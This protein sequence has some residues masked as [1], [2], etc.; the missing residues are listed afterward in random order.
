[1]NTVYKIM[2]AASLI[3]L[4][5]CEEQKKN[6]LRGFP[7][8]QFFSE[9]DYEPLTMHDVGSEIDPSDQ[10]WIYETRGTCG[11]VIA[12]LRQYPELEYRLFFTYVGKGP[13]P[14]LDELWVFALRPFK[15]TGIPSIEWHTYIDLPNLRYG[16]YE[17]PDEYVGRIWIELIPNSKN[18]T[19]GL[20]IRMVEQAIDFNS[21]IHK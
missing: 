11:S 4:S 18:K 14:N 8:S 19:F 13:M 21:S 10:P 7:A 17:L 16:E 20:H 12:P 1:M 2:L 15:D 6:T 5:A 3:G 9:F